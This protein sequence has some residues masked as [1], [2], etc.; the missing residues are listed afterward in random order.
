MN[1]STLFIAFLFVAILSFSVY[2]FF[3]THEYKDVT[4]YTPFKGEARE[5]PLFAARLF[6][7]EMGIPAENKNDLQSIGKQYPDSNSVI[8]LDTKRNTLSRQ[9][10][11]QLLA[12]VRDGGHLITPSNIDFNMLDYWTNRDEDDDK[13][14]NCPEDDIECQ[15]E[16]LE[17]DYREYIDESINDHLQQVLEVT[18]GRSVYIENPE[19]AKNT[20]NTESDTNESS[21]NP[22]DEYS[23]F[24][25]DIDY[26]IFSLWNIKDLRI[27]PVALSNASKKFDLSIEPHFYSMRSKETN[28]SRILIDDEI[29]MLQRAVGKGMITLTAEMTI[30]ENQL[31][32]ETDNAEFLWYLVHSNHKEPTTVWLFHNDEMPNLLTLMWRH[33]WA[34]M[35][36]LLALLLFWLYQSMHRFGPLIPKQQIARRRLMEHIEA[37]G[38]YFWKQKNKQTLIDSTR[39]ALNQ[40][41]ARL[42]PT[43]DNTDETGKINHLAEMLDLPADHIKHLLFENSISGDEDFTQLIRELESIRRQL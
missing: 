37:S 28:E 19:D 7:K 6:L 22:G 41:I 35:L 2:K 10:T 17:E 11:E 38:E 29:F 34:V 27:F 12:W 14:N 1:R 8:I 13:Q 18:S 15:D 39:L 32:R 40:R 9:R 42:H 4:E 31:L 21:D 25:E 33:G 20:D 43:W 5:N 24:E 26:D 23:D 16:Y 30:I 3:D 36:S